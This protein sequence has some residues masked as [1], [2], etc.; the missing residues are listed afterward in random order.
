MFLKKGKTT[1]QLKN[2]EPRA[3]VKNCVCDTCKMLTVLSAVTQNTLL[4]ASGFT[5]GP[6]T[7]ST[8]M[9]RGT[10]L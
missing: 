8:T 5:R 4:G 3:R 1:T 2:L 9:V 7:G 6:K 10:A